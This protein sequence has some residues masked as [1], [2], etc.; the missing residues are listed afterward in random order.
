MLDINKDDVKD[1]LD[2]LKTIITISSAAVG[3]LLYKFDSP[4]F[5]EL[6][7]IA[8]GC[9]TLTILLFV[10]VFTGLIDHKN[11]SDSQV[12]K[13]ISIPI[14]MGYGLFFTGFLMLLLHMLP[15]E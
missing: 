3:A 8:A 11:S 12:S 7:K 5:P 10:C 13:V 14:F 9:F 1:Y 15:I 2:W 6:I 4:T